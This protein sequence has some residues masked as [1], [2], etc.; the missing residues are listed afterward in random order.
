MNPYTSFAKTTL[1]RQKFIDLLMQEANITNAKATH[2]AARIYIS[3]LQVV[4]IN[5]NKLIT[6]IDECG[7][8][9][10]ISQRRKTA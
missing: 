7:Q 4:E 8:I 5:N 10:H 2:I 9:P 6:A 1:I 3:G